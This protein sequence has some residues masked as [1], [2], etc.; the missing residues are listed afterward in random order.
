M[1][2]RANALTFAPLLF[3]SCCCFPYTRVRLI[4]GVCVCVSECFFDRAKEAEDDNND[5]DDSHS[6]SDCDSDDV[7]EEKNKSCKENRV[8]RVLA[9]I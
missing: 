8:S 1:C 3:S 9:Y 4:V 5:D 6:H 7:D 2:V